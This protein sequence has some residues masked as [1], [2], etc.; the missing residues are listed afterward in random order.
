MRF[1]G[2]ISEKAT[3]PIPLIPTRTSL[4]A[5]PGAQMA[6]TARSSVRRHSQGAKRGGGSRGPQPTTVTSASRAGN[7]GP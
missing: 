2:L 3:H 5:R 7:V 4:H 6:G 1:W